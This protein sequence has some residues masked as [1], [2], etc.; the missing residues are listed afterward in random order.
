MRSV[1]GIIVLALMITGCKSEQPTSKP[2]VEPIVS[3]TIE[4]KQLPSLTHEQVIIYK[5]KILKNGDASSVETD[6]IFQT[7]TETDLIEVFKETFEHAERLSGSM[8]MVP[9][10]Y[11]VVIGSAEYYLLIGEDATD[12]IVKLEDTHTMYRLSPSATVKIREILS[13]SEPEEAIQGL[14]MDK[15]IMG[16]NESHRVLVATNWTEEDKK[17]TMDDL[18]AKA[19]QTRELAWYTV[20]E[21]V[22]TKL[23]VGQPI[24]IRAASEQLESYPPI[25]FVIT[26]Q[27]IEPVIEKSSLYLNL[28]EEELSNQQLLLTP[29]SLDKDW[30]LDGVKPHRY[31]VNHATKVNDSNRLEQLSIYIFNSEQQL[32]D[33]IIDFQKQT[34]RFDMLYPRIY[35][36]KNAMIFYWAHGNMDE[37]AKLGTYFENAIKL[38]MDK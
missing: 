33:G 28:I 10:T 20:D 24:A 15:K 26:T 35:K 21:A 19:L 22:Y 8:K 2:T 11:K 30:I 1:I 38:L 3:A 23:L 29:I 13:W 9:P 6:S 4:P 7:I 17:Y 37:P 5:L 31:T 27:L 32:E 14:V 12:S 34:E 16:Q 36:L 18:M 25:R